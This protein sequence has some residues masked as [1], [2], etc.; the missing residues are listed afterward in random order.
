[1]TISMCS[2]SAD[3]LLFQWHTHDLWVD[4]PTSVVEMYR[5]K[6]CRP[7]SALSP[8]DPILP[9]FNPPTQPSDA[10]SIKTM[11]LTNIGDTNSQKPNVQGLAAQ[12]G[13]AA[14]STVT[15][16]AVN[17][18]GKMGNQLYWCVDRAW[19]EP[20]ETWLCT[21]NADMLDNDQQLCNRLNQH[22]RRVR[23]FRGRF[24]SWKECLGVE[25]RSVSISNA[26]PGAKVTKLASLIAYTLIMF[27][28]YA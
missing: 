10:D 25:F 13:A 26:H 19:V 8:A 2:I 11:K 21:E 24:L 6:C 27:K 7:I 15:A 18:S 3:I 17:Q 22:Y 12:A 1:M 14:T 23:G 20:S 4:L 28:S 16:L 9:Q 5:T